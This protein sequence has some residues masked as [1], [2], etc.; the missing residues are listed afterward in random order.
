MVAEET[1]VIQSQFDDLITADSIKAV[2]RRF[3]N[4][5]VILFLKF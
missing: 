5:H 1:S 2:H 4:E 3:E